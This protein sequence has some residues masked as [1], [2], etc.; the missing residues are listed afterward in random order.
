MV[1]QAT[2]KYLSDNVGGVL[3][4]A[5]GEMT[6]A[7]PRDG[8]GFLAK[9]LQLHVEQEEERSEREKQQA[10]LVEQRAKAQEQLAAKAA[11]KA[12]KEA[13]LERKDNLYKH[14]MA[15]FNDAETSFEDNFWSEL[16][17]VASTLTGAKA[18]YLG[19]VDEEGLE[20]TPG[21]LIRYTEALP[22]SELMLDKT[23]QQGQGVTWGAVTENP[24]EEVQHLWKPPMPE[25]AEPNPDDPDATPPEP[26]VIPY[27]PVSVECVTDVKEMHYFDLTRLGAYFAVPLVYSSYYTPEAY[28][29]CKAFEEEK[30]AEAK[31]RDEALQAFEAQQE[32]VRSKEGDE[33]ADALARPPELDAVDEKVMELP[34]KVVKMVL[35]M[36][37]LGTNTAI[38]EATFER[39]LEL[40]KACGKCKQETEKRQLDDQ[41]RGDID[42]EQRE[43][44]IEDI[45]AV[46]TRVE[47][48]TDQD[49]QN[50]EAT[51]EEGAAREQI[52]KKWAFE[53]ARKVFLE[54]KDAFLG[55]KSWVVPNQDTMTLI[56]ASALFFGFKKEDLYPKGK[57]AL[58]WQVLVHILDERFIKAIQDANCEAKRQNLT[59]E[60]KLA[61]VKAMKAAEFDS[62]K[63]KEVS[64][65]LELLHAL[66]EAAV[67]YRTGHLLQTKA[68]W[69]STKAEKEEAGEEFTEEP[70]EKTDDDFEGL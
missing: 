52:G 41:A 19:L 16:L 9:W 51:A 47:E 4:K 65:A 29:A 32:E 36:D 21:P 5:L 13:E 30:K 63:A 20:G 69:E 55:L 66:F 67:E 28:A 26:P 17:S 70:L 14:L 2:A 49:M 10:R 24:G 56:A 68:K 61:A 62:E 64:P 34:G 53:R 35:C 44:L 25:P 58:N 15:K 18:V 57:S 6:V 42:D 33:A 12:A 23:L 39:A 59:P 60:Q 3:A 48:E 27:L 8:V 11:R 38:D 54:L 1:D 50:D 22:G 31:K 7:Q 37:T 45:A 46:R 40:C 43:K